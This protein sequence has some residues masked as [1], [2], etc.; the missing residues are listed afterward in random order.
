MLASVFETFE[1]VKA[2]YCYPNVL[3]VY[4]IL[5]IMP[6]IVTFAEK[7]FSNLNLLKNYLRSLMLER[8]KKLNDAAILCIEK[9]MTKHIDVDTIICYPFKSTHRKCFERSFGY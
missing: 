9:Y 5:L 8:K 1:F 6:V 7:S 3:I 4:G 2:V